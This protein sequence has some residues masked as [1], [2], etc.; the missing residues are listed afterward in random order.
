MK[1]WVSPGL[2]EK[3]NELCPGAEVVTE[4]SLMDGHWLCSDE[5][6]YPLGKTPAKFVGSFAIDDACDEVLP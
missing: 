1:I 4:T 3:A 2:E 6:W 5:K